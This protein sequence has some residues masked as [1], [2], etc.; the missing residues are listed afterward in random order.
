MT[1]SL[2][3]S[4]RQQLGM[5]VTP[6][7]NFTWDASADNGTAKLARGNAGA[8]TQDVM[9]VN[10]AGQVSFEQNGPT[11]LTKVINSTT[12]QTISA[13]AQNHGLTGSKIRSISLAINYQASDYLPDGYIGTSASPF[14]QYLID[15]YWNSTQVFMVP[16][17]NAVAA[18]LGKPCVMTIQY[19]I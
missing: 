17:A 19:E 18:V 13:T 5:S 8:T 1:M 11:L 3:K 9:S 16:Y 4:I 6:A 14:G 10:A 7:N 15:I 12:P 2:I